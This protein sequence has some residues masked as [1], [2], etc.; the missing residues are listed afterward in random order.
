MP[1]LIFGSSCRRL[2]RRSRIVPFYCVDSALCVHH[3]SLHALRET[4]T[5]VRCDIQ[6]FGLVSNGGQAASTNSE[7]VTERIW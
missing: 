2:R 7:T 4:A 3:H 1:S 5:M 6:S